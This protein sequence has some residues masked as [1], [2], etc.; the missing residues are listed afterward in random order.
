MAPLIAALAL[1]PVTVVVT[2]PDPQGVMNVQ[3]CQEANFLGGPCAHGQSRAAEPRAAFEFEAVEPGRWAI[4]VWRDPEG[5][6]VMR[7]ALFGIPRE[8]T[9]ISNDPPARFG[10]P[11]FDDA[12]IEIGAEPVVFEIEVD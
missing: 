12:A 4:M 3:L 2:T 9:A 8:P 6:G 7:Q 10:P 5:D 11:Q 1:T